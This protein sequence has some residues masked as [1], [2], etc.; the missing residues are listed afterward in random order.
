M[1]SAVERF[2]ACAN[3]SVREATRGALDEFAQDVALITLRLFRASPHFEA[4]LCPRM[5][6]AQLMPRI[7]EEGAEAFV[8]IMEEI[9]G[10]IRD[11]NLVTDSGTVLRLTALHALQIS[12]SYPE[13]VPSLDFQESAHYTGDNY[14][15]F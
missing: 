5:S 9:A 4:F 13:T 15:N 12:T 11:L 3:L 7:R 14:E 1:Q 8:R 6:T 2:A 10:R